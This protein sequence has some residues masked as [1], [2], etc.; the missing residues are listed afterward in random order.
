MRAGE[1]KL[2]RRAA[3]S[4]RT[5]AAVVL[6]AFNHRQVELMLEADPSKSEWTQKL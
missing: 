1:Y 6:Y 4:L 3:T 5:L 2:V